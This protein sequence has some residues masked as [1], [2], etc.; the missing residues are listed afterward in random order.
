MCYFLRRINDTI[1]VLKLRCR[2]DANWILHRFLESPAM[3]V[4]VSVWLIT[5]GKLF[6]TGCGHC[7]WQGSTGM[8]GSEESHSVVHL[9]V[10]LIYSP[11]VVRVPVGQ[12]KA[13]GRPPLPLCGYV[14]WHI[15]RRPAGHGCCDRAV[16]ANKAHG[17][18]HFCL[19][20]RE[21]LGATF[22][23]FLLVS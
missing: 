3:Y 11:P 22:P 18:S 16:C 21:L 9:V 20:R 10:T 5:P 6:L 19:C 14:Q 2:L 23:L 7:A 13:P 15:V 17:R 8:G 12:A 4:H 1:L